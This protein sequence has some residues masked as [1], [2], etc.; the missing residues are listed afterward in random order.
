LRRPEASIVALLSSSV[1]FGKVVPMVYG[2]TLFSGRE[3]QM[4]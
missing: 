1:R 4:F 2:R 3:L